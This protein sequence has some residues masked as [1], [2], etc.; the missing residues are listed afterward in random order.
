MTK[1]ETWGWQNTDLTTLTC[2]HTDAGAKFTLTATG[3]NGTTDLQI[4]QCFSLVGTL[5]TRSNTSDWGQLRKCLEQS[6]QEK[7][8]WH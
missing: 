7:S 3:W 6:F 2:W 8:E 4:M 5:R 1:K